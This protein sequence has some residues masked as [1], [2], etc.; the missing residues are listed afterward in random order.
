MSFVNAVAPPA[1]PMNRFK[2]VLTSLGLAFFAGANGRAQLQI[3]LTNVGLA[4]PSISAVTIQLGGTTRSGL[5]TPFIIP[6]GVVPDS[7]LWFCID[8]LQT[9]YYSGS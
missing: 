6:A 4:Y 7:L 9:I 2:I 8:P 1:P 5:P 3:S